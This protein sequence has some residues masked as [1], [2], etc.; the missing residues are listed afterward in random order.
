[1]A[2][3]TGA[4]YTTPATT[5]A[6]SG[7]TFRCI[8]SNSAGSATSNPATLTVTASAGE[9]NHAPKIVT[10]VPS[11]SKQIIDT[12]MDQTHF[13]VAADFDGDGDTDVVATDYVDDTVAWYENNG[14]GGFTKRVID[15]SLDG[16]YPVFVTDLNRDGA[17]DVLATG[18]L[19]DMAVWYENN[20]SGGFTKRVID[21]N[22]DGAHS[23]YPTDL[24]GDGDTDVVGGNQD[25]NSVVWYENDGSSNFIEHSPIDVGALGAKSVFAADL[26]GDNDIDIAVASFHDDKISWYEND[27]QQNFV[28]R[29]IDTTVDGAYF[30]LGTDLDRDSD[31]DLVTASQNDDTVAWYE[32]NGSGGFTKRAID[33]FAD[34]ARAVFVA[35]VDGDGD[36]DVLA[37]SPHDHTIAWY[38]N[39]GGS[40][41]SRHLIDYSARGAYGVSA[42][43]VDGDGHIDIIAASRDDNTVALHYQTK[44]HY[45]SLPQGGTLTID[46]SLLEARDDEDPPTALTYTVSDLPD[47]GVLQLNG[48][49]LTQGGTFTQADIDSN[50]VVY[51]H[52]GASTTRD[53]FALTLTD[54]G[55][56]GVKPGSGAFTLNIVDPS[57]P[58]VKSDDFNA[59]GLAAYWS[60][61][62]PAGT[63]SNL[64]RM[65]DEAY[66]E[67]VVPSGDYDVFNTNRGARVMQDALNGDFEVEAK[68]LSRP[69]QRFQ[70]QGI[71][72]EQDANNWLRFDTYH[73][74][75]N[76]RIFIGVTINGVS[77]QVV[78]RVVAAAAAS[79]LRVTRTG[80]VW[81][82]KYSADGSTWTTTGE[83]THV[84]NVTKVGPFAG[85][86]GTSPGYTA[87][88]DYFFNTAAPIANED[89]G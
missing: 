83:F 74:G 87:Q 27:G 29:S 89:G 15:S 60:F 72:V 28:K 56:D 63:G 23:L 78:N 36:S 58:A 65:G 77:K 54:G 49:S 52:N 85:S 25:G 32:N 4:S 82:L 45:V 14:N 55:Q 8:V 20:G 69:T 73:D 10:G 57:M 9:V 67:L 42:A 37:S 21:A 31:I 46:T 71:L 38:R 48:V 34:G 5:L 30:V 75:T 76:L 40:S 53:A 2:G 51:V 22:A 19:A 68:F 66:L 86:T 16:A 13:A 80:D 59:D 64:V 11:F 3:A 35:D 12:T 17:I 70:L 24:D 79:Y 7:A 84:L 6:D 88:V 44:A 1:I 33:T 26:D 62:G 18:Y 50:R 41:F 81:T 61:T 39:D 47:F 43:N